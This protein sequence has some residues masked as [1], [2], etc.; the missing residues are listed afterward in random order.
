MS[1]QA[2]TALKERT[3]QHCTSESICCDMMLIAP[4]SF[5][6]H[7]VAQHLPPPAALAPKTK[8][9]AYKTYCGDSNTPLCLLHKNLHS[10]MP[11]WSLLSLSL[12]P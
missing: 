7:T 11:N 1:E 2:L 5:F 6:I 4:N 10:N 8:E 3:T 9:T 12:Q